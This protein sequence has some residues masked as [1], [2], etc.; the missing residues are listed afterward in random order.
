MI[1]FFEILIPIVLFNPGTAA[2]FLQVYMV[3]QSPLWVSLMVGNGA[4]MLLQVYRVRKNLRSVCGHSAQDPLI[5]FVRRLRFW[6][7]VNFFATSVMLFA[8]FVLGLVQLTKDEFHPMLWFTQL[9]LLKFSN[10]GLTLAQAEISAPA[11]KRNNRQ[12]A[13]TG[14]T[15]PRTST[16]SNSA[17]SSTPQA[18]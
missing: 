9:S 7:Y 14:A 6:V 5:L 8:M 3:A 15:M 12:V 2:E 10:A 13:A 16:K 17:I 1:I 4:Y 11:K 18:K